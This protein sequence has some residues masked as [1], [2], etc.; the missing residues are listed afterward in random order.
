MG[1]KTLEDAVRRMD[2]L[3][4]AFV[5]VRSNVNASGRNN[6]KAEVKRI[7]ENPVPYLRTIQRDLQKRRFTFLE[8]HG[9]PKKKPTGKRRPIV[10]SPVINRVVQRAILN[11][12]QSEDA[13]TVKLLGE[14]ADTLRTPTSVGGVPKRGVSFG[15]H[16]VNKAIRAGAT[17]YLQSDIR[18]FFTEVPKSRVVAFVRNQTGDEKFAELLDEALTTELENKDAIKEW[19]HLFPLDD[20]GVPQGSSL[21]AFAGNVVLRD[22]DRAMNGRTITTVRYIDDFVILGRSEPAVRNAFCSAISI[23]RDLGMT[24][25][26]L[27]QHTGKARMGPVS[28]GFDFLGCSIRANGVTPSR[29]SQKNL[30]ENIRRTLNATSQS[31]RAYAS[32]DK[33]RRAEE[34]FVQVLV[35]VDGIIRGWGDAFSFVDNR[36]PFHQLDTKIDQ[37]LTD[38]RGLTSRF[39]NSA[40]VEDRRRRALGI[41]LLKDTPRLAKDRQ[42]K[43]TVELYN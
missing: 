43:Q 14:I 32:A 39:I 17:H 37:I 1:G 42:E 18:D 31:I 27:E 16:L 8:Q 36:L 13:S 25:Y 41:A 28:D 20:I 34:A 7:S 23:L 19:L 33:E 9:I 26:R 35:R 11:V 22:F 38:F 15:I 5:I 3:Y 12:L 24:A 40:V 10:V 6:F 4:R 2:N 29:K 21:S 30:L